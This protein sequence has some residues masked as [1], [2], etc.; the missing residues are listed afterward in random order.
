LPENYRSLLNIR[1][2]IEAM[3]D[4][5]RSTTTVSAWNNFDVGSLSDNEVLC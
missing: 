5:C 1:N 2:Y 3:S 4:E